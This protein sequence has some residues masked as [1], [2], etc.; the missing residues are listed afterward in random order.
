MNARLLA[1]LAAASFV[2]TSGVCAA[3][4]RAA[5]TEERVTRTAEGRGTD[6][7]ADELRDPTTYELTRRKPGEIEVKPR[8]T[9]G[10]KSLQ[11]PMSSGE[12]WI[13][14]ARADFYVD[15]DGD[16]YYRFLRVQ[17][18]ADTIHTMTDVYAEIYLSAD[19][20]SWEFLHATQDFSIWG[21]DEDDDYEVETELVSGYSTGLYDVLVELYD[22]DTG[23]F[24]DEY[25][26]NESPDFSMLPLEDSGRDGIV[27]TQPPVTIIEEH[28]G[29]GAVSWLALLGLA[30]ALALRRKRVA[31]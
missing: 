24:L 5:G 2:L 8:A 4:T 31:A 28:G 21:T 3:Q 6:H 9:G 12:S 27:V 14:D 23:E 30:G 25:G 7:P 1:S 18:D 15:T 26:P 16:G 17:L 20:T 13:Y 22:S 10:S 29:G 11:K 19:G